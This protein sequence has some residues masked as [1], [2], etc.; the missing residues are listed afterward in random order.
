MA[1]R[2]WK[3]SGRSRAHGIPGRPA[4]AAH[5]RDRLARRRAD[6]ADRA[7][8]VAGGLI[9]DIENTSDY[10]HAVRNEAISGLADMIDAAESRDGTGALR[11]LGM[12]IFDLDNPQMTADVVREVFA[13]ADGSIGEQGRAGGREGVARRDR[14]DAPAL[15]RCGRCDR[16]ALVW[17]P[18]AGSRCRACSRPVPRPGPRR[19]CRCWTEQYVRPDGSLMNDAELTDL[20]RGAWR[21]SAP[22][23]T[24]RPSRASTAAAARAPTV[25]A[26]TACCTSGTATPGWPT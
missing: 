22:A 8:P 5:R 12:R 2:R 16:Q 14:E 19:C 9:R 20:L 6:A 26:I 17:L 3:T 4:G 13:N 24:A 7:H 1:K 11:N 23:V 21:R 18:V 15:Q 25:A 10:V